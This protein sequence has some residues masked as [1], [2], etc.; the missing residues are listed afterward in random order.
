MIAQI[1]WTVRGRG[2]KILNMISHSS[3]KLRD[4]LSPWPTIP[5]AQFVNETLA[6]RQN[7]WRATQI[8]KNDRLD[9][10]VNA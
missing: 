3:I 6:L 8:Q 4:G 5:L 2:T 1:A 9:P 10:F 7:S